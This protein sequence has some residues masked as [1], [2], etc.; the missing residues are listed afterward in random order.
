MTK[1]VMYIK[2]KG[3]TMNRQ[4]ALREAARRIESG[5]YYAWSSPADC[6]CG[7][8]AQVVSHRDRHQLHDSIGVISCWSMRDEAFTCPITDL[9][10][11][12]IIRVLRETGFTHEDICSIEFLSDENVRKRAGMVLG[13]YSTYRQ[14]K[15]QIVSRLGKRILISNDRANKFAV[16]KYFRAMAN[17][18]DEQE[19][20]Y[21]SLPVDDVMFQ[22]TPVAVLR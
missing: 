16:V 1:M 17:V 4:E 15:L 7:I 21:A 8:V 12:Y 13:E 19:E 3:E 5:A 10:E 2:Q 9:P 14:Q 6:N 11:N 22:T 18:L 20:E